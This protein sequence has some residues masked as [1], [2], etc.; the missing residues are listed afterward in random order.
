MGPQQA[1][2]AYL[3]CLYTYHMVV[4]VVVVYGLAG[5]KPIEIVYTL[6]HTVA[7]RKLI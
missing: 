5:P 4:V 6:T 3:I 1:E 7:N 2:E